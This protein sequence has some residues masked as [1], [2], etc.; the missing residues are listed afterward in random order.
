MPQL[1]KGNRSALGAVGTLRSFVS[2]L[3]EISF[4]DV[5]EQAEQPPR[6]LVLAPTADEASRLATLLVGEDVPRSVSS[7]ALDDADARVGAYDAVVVFDPEGT[8]AVPRLRQRLGTGDDAIPVFPLGGDRIE[9]ERVLASLRAAITNRLPDLGPSFG[10]H[11]PAFRAAATKA[12]LTL[13]S[14]IT[15]G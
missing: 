4:D 6:L 1:R 9:D 5:R 14:T 15:R 12:G 3:R 11:C 2:V 13:R 8:G 10:R 7:R